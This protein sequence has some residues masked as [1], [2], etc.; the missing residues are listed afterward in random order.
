MIELFQQVCAAAGLAQ[1]CPFNSAWCNSWNLVMIESTEEFQ[2]CPCC[3]QKT[4]ATFFRTVDDRRI[5][6][7]CADRAEESKASVLA[8]VE[9][10]RIHGFKVRSLW[11]PF[12]VLVGAMLAGILLRICLWLLEKPQVTDRDYWSVGR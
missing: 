8:Y 11:K 10:R 5:C 9:D 12:L 7:L 4:A 3:S 1:Q 2:I 6:C